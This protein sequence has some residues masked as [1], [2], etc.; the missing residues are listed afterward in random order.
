[1]FSSP[2]NHSLKFPFQIFQ[3]T[4]LVDGSL[5]VSLEVLGR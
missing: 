5:V 3:L 2:E 1:M 4:C